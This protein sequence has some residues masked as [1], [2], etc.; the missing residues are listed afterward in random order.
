MPNTLAHI[1]INGFSTKKI[2]ASSSLLWIYLGC[3]IPDIPWIIRKIISV[4]SPSING[5]D[6]QAYVIVQATLFFS[7]ILSF[8]FSL[9]S[10]NILKTFLILS[11]GS[12]LHLL[13]DPIQIKWANGVHLFA[14]FSWDMT[15]YGIFW[16]ESF[17]T[18]L[19]TISGVIFFVFY[20]K[21]LKIIKPN[22]LFKKI[23]SFLAFL[24]ILIY[25]VLPLIFM[26]NVVKSDN[27]FIS[28]LKIENE[29]IGKYVEMDR[30]DVTFNEQTN[31]YWIKSFNKDLIELKNIERL[32]SNRIS[33]KGRFISNNLI[34]VIEYHE[35][36][37]AFRDGASYLGILLI[38]FS[39]ILAFRNS[40]K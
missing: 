31:S 12:L 37:E 28:T 20:W 1:A 29:R 24:I 30:K 11:F 23:N 17:I 7:I 10:K 15:T 21:E 9:F 4:L 14:P 36:W 27:H 22:I 32:Y 26:N 38:I 35:N 2:S 33:I 18:Y 34:S 3:I 5:Y 16:P 39:W 6:L 25:F 13:L 40:L 19:M 8:S